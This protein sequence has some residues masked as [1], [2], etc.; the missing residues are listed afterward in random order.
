M[1]ANIH[2]FKKIVYT[3]VL[4][5]A[6]V[7]Q[8]LCQNVDSSNL[9]LNV[10]DSLIANQE[11]LESFTQ[12]LL[13][14]TSL[15]D[16]ILKK[17][18][19][20][21]ADYDTV[22]IIFG[23]DDIDAP[24]TYT[25][26]DSIVYDVKN[27]KVYLH[28]EADMKYE[29]VY[30]QSDLIR[31]DWTTSVLLAEGVEDSLGN[32][33]GTP[34]FKDKDQEYLANK[35]EYNFSN[36]KGK[37]YDVFTEEGGAF[38]HTKV[39]KRNEFE[40]WFG[41]KTWF[42]TCE[43]KDHPHFYIEANRS[44]VIPGKLIVTGPANLKV[45]G[46]N[47]PLVLPFALF[48][49]NKERRSG[50]I[51]P[52]YGENA[53]LGIF[54]R[55]L[56]YYWAVSDKLSLAFT[57]DIYTRG[58]FR[59][60][61]DGN[62]VKRYKYNGNFSL[63]YTRTPP[64]E[65]FVSKAGLSNDFRVEWSH[66]MDAKANPNNSFSA[67]VTGGSRSFN[68][69][70]LVTN[71]Q[72]LEAQ[73]SS[74]ITYGRRF[75]GKPYSFSMNARHNQ[76][77][78]TGQVQLT[79]PEAIFNVTRLQPF[80]RKVRSEKKKF[81]ESIGIQYNTRAKAFIE[82]A[83]STFFSSETLNNIQTGIQHTATIDAPFNL[84]K[85]FSI[86][87]AFNY[88]E[89]W[90]FKEETQSFD[91]DTTFTMVSDSFERDI[92]NIREDYE[93]GFFD[94][95]NFS[96]NTDISTTITGIFNFK[97]D[98]I[99]AIRHVIKPN[100]RHTFTPDFGNERW[101]VYDT[102]YDE[103]QDRLIQYNQFQFLNGL[104][105]TPGQGMQNALNFSVTNN[106]EMKKLNKKDSVKSYKN[107]PIID[108][109]TM[110]MG[111]NFAADSLKIQDLNIRA[112]SS[113]FNN[114]VTW[115]YSANFSAY[116]VDSTNRRINTTAWEA[117]RRLMRLRNMSLAVNINLNPK[118]KP[119]MR[120]PTAGTIQERDYVLNNPEMFYDF[121][122]PWSL[123]I[124][125]NAGI[126]KG[127]QQNPDSLLFSLNSLTVVGHINITPKWQINI[128]SGYNV[129]DKDLTLTNVRVE[130]DLHCWVLA[131]Q[132]TAY[133]IEVQTFAI[134]LHVKSPLLQEL[135]LSRKQPPNRTGAF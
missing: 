73:L 4:H 40:E 5:F 23:D 130:R 47:T 66:T 122:I 42:T 67:S 16:S 44:K 117:E 134:D 84:F 12:P 88:T 111:Y 30:I 54:F 92:K 68:Q 91:P 3:F 119:Q 89:R 51:F 6:I 17:P 18:S 76:D 59:V 97:G 43:N 102:Y 82:G 50:I 7:G 53:G 118:A 13:N 121:N 14:D 21:K 61:V 37:I 49:S 9:Q 93:T 60:G 107:V 64:T 127:T 41:Q 98:K 114:V 125:Y 39:V 2:T 133:P 105:G 71:E 123:R 113:L 100:L 22:E 1:Q 112:F 129:R 74:N 106:F 103:A 83:D 116:T 72:S 109:L 104:Y 56:G 10:I 57:S 131:F 124:G 77:M 29:D 90:Y 65:K 86:K 132:W 27:E 33:V 62:Y 24:I 48:P 8:I 25:A 79:L 70:T 135:K 120:N 11:K 55:N 101:G 96:V 35:M 32:L 95:R 38:L 80:Q 63:S 52:E 94:L 108:N 81:Y 126:T 15:Q 75:Q 46:V 128:T 99:K 36:R 26:L 28:Q 20:P 115:N 78:T 45:Q 58:T 85:H 69:N 34:I 87:P 19:A 110:N 31:F